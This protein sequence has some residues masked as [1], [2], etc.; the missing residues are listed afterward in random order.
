MCGALS[1]CLCTPAQHSL[2]GGKL[3]HNPPQDS[4][5]SR[6]R[7][8]VQGLV[9]AGE[10]FELYGWSDRQAPPLKDSTMHTMG[11]ES[12]RD[13]DEKQR[14]LAACLAS[15]FLFDNSNMGR[16]VRVAHEQATA[17]EQERVRARWAASQTVGGSRALPWSLLFACSRKQQE[18]REHLRY[19]VGDLYLRGKPLP[20]AGNEFQNPLSC[21]AML[22]A[23]SV[24]VILRSV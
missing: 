22:A 11:P 6:H 16:D 17:E 7:T 23:P 19:V 3:P 10:C 15:P 4:S 24:P 18:L 1:V 21:S 20:F 13:R 14:S 12:D 2:Q 8:A 9:P 5:T